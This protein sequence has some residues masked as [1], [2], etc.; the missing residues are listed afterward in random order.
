MHFNGEYWLKPSDLG[1]GN[2]ENLELGVN[3]SCYRVIDSEQEI[4]PPP[5]A[6]DSFRNFGLFYGLDDNLVAL[7]FQNLTK[8]IQREQVHGRGYWVY[9]YMFS[10]EDITMPGKSPWT[11]RE[12]L[13]HEGDVTLLIYHLGATYA[14]EKG[15][16]PLFAT[17]PLNTTGLRVRDWTTENQEQR[18]SWGDQEL[19]KPKK[20][21]VAVLCNTTYLLCDS[22]DIPVESGNCLKLGG[23]KKV[24]AFVK[25]IREATGQEQ[26]DS[27][28][29]GFLDLFADIAHFGG[30]DVAA[31]A[32]NGIF[33][34]NLL[35]GTLK[36]QQFLDQVSGQQELT[37]LF[38]ST[39]TR[40]L[41]A[42]RRAVLGE[43]IQPVV[44][45]GFHA[46]D[47]LPTTV[48]TKGLTAMCRATLIPDSKFKTTTAKPWIIVACVWLIVILL[49]Y[50][51]PLVL[52]FHWRWAEDI[53]RKW[54]ARTAV[55]LYKQLVVEQSIG[56]EIEITSFRPGS[57]GTNANTSALLG[58]R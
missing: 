11:P 15:D 28:R 2:I 48:A 7:G 51:T 19:F 39:R 25:A 35:I 49:T 3:T 8:V 16:D 33:A 45:M 29:Q 34:S 26:V 56:T 20:Q 47:I 53:E 54:M 46:D 10:E 44:Q 31:A 40:F 50:S 21:T 24:R 38:L 22:M 18:T 5:N 32:L 30:M 6:T 23:E 55:S 52:M 37:R 41:L 4:T 14:L 12:D 27:P 13:H 17:I 36:Y 42:A 58:R 43:W 57:S 1:V 9:P